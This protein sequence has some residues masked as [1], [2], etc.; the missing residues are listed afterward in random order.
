MPTLGPMK[1]VDWLLLLVVLIV[2]G[3]AR[4]YYVQEF[5]QG[6]QAEP[7]AVY[8][9]QS[10]PTPQD[11]V[12]VASPAFS[13][14]RDFV[15]RAVEEQGGNQ[16]NPLAAIRW[17]HVVLGTLTA[18]L[19]F[20][21]GRRAFGSTLVGLLAGLFVAANPFAIINVGEIQD[22]TLASFLL[23]VSLTAG[24]TAGQRA[25][26]IS[27]ILFGLSLAGLVLIRLALVPFA[28][29]ALIWFL[30]RCSN[31]RQGWLAALV[32]F[33]AFGAAVG[34]WMGHNYHRSGEPLPIVD[35]AWWHLW[36]GNNPQATGGPPEPEPPQLPPMPDDKKPEGEKPALAEPRAKGPDPAGLGHEELARQVLEEVTQQPIQTVERRVA[37]ALWFF[38]G[39]VENHRLALVQE[40]VREPGDDP[41][42]GLG[43]ALYCTLFGM[44]FLALI[45]WRW[46]YAWRYYSMPLQLAVFWVPLPYVLSHAEAMHG[47]R[48][49]LDGVLLTLAAFTVC[50]LV[51]G[52]GGRLLR[53][54][55][56][57]SAE[58]QTAAQQPPPARM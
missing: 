34:S 54:E 31:V 44:L 17:L 38:T 18:G 41:L 57:V 36:L 13:V 12:H 23:A 28:L 4:G 48:L 1:L 43:D 24:A 7:A 5:T 6:G 51:P 25:G 37:A 56:P 10:D 42:P 21:L 52:L 50:C 39:R 19:Y 45:G 55:L 3:A 14:C 47:P 40:P 53:G 27:S 9:V 35:T 22:G 30:F 11:Q 46:S 26:A 2:A 16:I 49:P 58:A 20:A 29:V 8:R 15:L 32:G 33:L